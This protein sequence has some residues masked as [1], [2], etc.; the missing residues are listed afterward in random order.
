MGECLPQAGRLV[1][2]HTFT[3]HVWIEQAAGPKSDVAQHLGVEPVVRAASPE[4]VLGIVHAVAQRGPLAEGAAVHH[5]PQ[6][7]LEIPAAVVQLDGQPVEQLRMGRL[8]PLQAKI[9]RR[10]DQPC[11]K[12][13]LPDAVDQHTGDDRLLAAGEPPGQAKPVA[14]RALRKGIHHLEH[15]RL[16]RLTGWQVVFAAIE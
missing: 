3:A 14:R 13:T 4:F 2:L 16:Q 6:H 5:Q 12:D 1:R 11:A 8:L 10:A 7:V 9:L 15:V